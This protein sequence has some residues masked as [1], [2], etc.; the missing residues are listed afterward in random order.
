MLRADVDAAAQKIGAAADGIGTTEP[1]PHLAGVQAAL[2][3]SQSA[4]A[5]QALAESWGTAV[6]DLSRDLGALRD[7]MGAAAHHLEAED[8]VVHTAFRRPMAGAL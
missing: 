1:G 6:S 8:E 5:A 2:P 4:G 7:P 3:D